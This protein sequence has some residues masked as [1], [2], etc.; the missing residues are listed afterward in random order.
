MR[1]LH[2]ERYCTQSKSLLNGFNLST[3]IAL[4][5]LYAVL[6]EDVQYDKR[7]L[8]LS[9]PGGGLRGPDD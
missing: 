2:A 4:C 5:M 8:T 9:A 1:F 3:D 6:G 7:V